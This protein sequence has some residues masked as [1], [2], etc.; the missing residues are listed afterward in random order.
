[1]KS[2]QAA[3]QK[4]LDEANERAEKQQATVRQSWLDHQH[5]VSPN[6]S[7]HLSH[8]PLSD[9]RSLPS[10]QLS[11]LL[12][13][14]LNWNCRKEQ[15]KALCQS[16]DAQLK[17]RRPDMYYNLRTCT[18]LSMLLA[19]IVTTFP[20]IHSSCLMLHFLIQFHTRVSN[21]SW[22]FH[23]VNQYIPFNKKVQH[24]LKVMS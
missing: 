7:R 17:L 10:S 19:S 4:Q 3:L 9:P 21:I 1:M 23:S 12:T 6:Q 13:S 20:S 22:K 16:P 15:G 5:P 8:S 24:S 18:Y 2:L 14:P 11:R